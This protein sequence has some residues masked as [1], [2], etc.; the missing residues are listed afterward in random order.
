MAVM[1]VIWMRERAFYAEYTTEAGQQPR[2]EEQRAQSA[3]GG[4]WTKVVSVR[5]G[6]VIGFTAGPIHMSRE[7]DGTASCWI[8]HAK[9]AG[10]LIADFQTVPRGPCAAS[11]TVPA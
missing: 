7:A 6:Q 1:V 9:G 11:Y 8:Y 5:P 3:N 2:R 10:G 4:W